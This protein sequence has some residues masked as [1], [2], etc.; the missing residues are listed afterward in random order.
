MAIVTTIIVL[1]SYKKLKKMEKRLKKIEDMLN[2][3]V[4]EEK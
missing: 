3:L 1:K 2:L 4:V